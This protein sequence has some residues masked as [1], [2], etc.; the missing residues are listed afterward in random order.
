[1]MQLQTKAKTLDH[2]KNNTVSS[3][4][5]SHQ[6]LYQTC[7]NLP[8]YFISLKLVHLYLMFLVSFVFWKLCCSFALSLIRLWDEI[9]CKFLKVPVLARQVFFI[10]IWNLD[11]Q[12]DMFCIK[13]K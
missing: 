10:L 7:S 12:E 3:S 13:Q 6:T 9:V 1:M 11:L 4:M 5:L 2:I 8:Q